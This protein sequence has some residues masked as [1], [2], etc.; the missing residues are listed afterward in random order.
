MRPEDRALRRDQVDRQ[1]A[2][3]RRRPLSRPARGWVRALR[4]AL[5]INGNQLARRMRI[6]RS[7][8]SQ[9][10]D[11]EARGVVSLNTLQRAADALDC[12]LVYAF[13]PRDGKTLEELVHERAQR[14]AKRAVEQVAGT[15]ALEDQRTSNEF[16]KLEVERI[17]A[18]LI[19]SMDRRL[20][21]E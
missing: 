14:V 7:Q 3:L 2:P 10:E 21:D 17:A 18:D 1:L 13:V 8:L 5:G 19:R 16:R 4:E 15:M 20:W 6:A 9:I 12:D 11:G